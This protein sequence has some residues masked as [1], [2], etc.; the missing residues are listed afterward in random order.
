MMNR[1]RIRFKGRRYGGETGDMY[2]SSKSI[3]IG[4]SLEGEG[5][6]GVHQ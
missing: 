1:D 2:S 3:Q 4:S 5:A 6:S